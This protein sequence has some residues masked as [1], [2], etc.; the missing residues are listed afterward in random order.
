MTF[1]LPTPK[2]AALIGW[3]LWF[4]AALWYRTNEA[5]FLPCWALLALVFA[6]QVV[7]VS[8]GSWQGGW[9]LFSLGTL[10]VSAVAMLL[11]ARLVAFFLA[12]RDEA[13]SI[14]DFISARV[15][16]VSTLAFLV[17]APWTF[18]MRKSVSRIPILLLYA[19][20]G[21]SLIAALVQFAI[22]G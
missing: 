15:F 2:L 10:L 13:P 7:A 21:L 3:A 17:T 1:R 20:V 5:A 22:A 14:S 19:S 11:G 18:A 8:H 6:L 9:W 4:C 12:F 16:A